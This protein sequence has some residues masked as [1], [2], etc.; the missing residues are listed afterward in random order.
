MHV[1]TIFAWLCSGTVAVHVLEQVL[2]YKTISYVGK[3]GQHNVIH[4]QT[5]IAWLSCN[6]IFSHVM[7]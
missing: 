7:L 3:E 6:C 2:S 1:Q 5:D 4:T